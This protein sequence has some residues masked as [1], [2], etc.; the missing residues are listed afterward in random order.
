MEQDV[1]SVRDWLLTEWS[2]AISAVLESMADER[3]LVERGASPG[4]ANTNVSP[5][6]DASIWRQ[7]SALMDGAAIWISVSRSTRVDLGKKVLTSAGVDD[8]QE[9]DCK[10]VTLELISQSMS[11]LGKAVAAN[12][13][14]KAFADSGEE[15]ANAPAG[16]VWIP[17][18]FSFSGTRLEPVWFAAEDVFVSKLASVSSMTGDAGDP[19]ALAAEEP[20]PDSS[21]ANGSKTL[22]LLMDVAL[23]VSV[24]FGRTVLPV[25]EVLRLSTGSIVELD[26]A[27]NEPVDVIVNDCVIARGEVVV[28]EGNY[29]VRI[30]QI[31][32][33]HDRLR[34]GTAGT[35][36]PTGPP[37]NGG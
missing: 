24:S 13:N 16:L 37:A 15:I 17:L 26:R 25:H 23:P 29:G 2:E 22:E 31:A 4:S 10:S 21:P 6:E 11:A 18:T 30:Q 33:R 35:R 5:G 27:I 20:F 36:S 9:E 7:D 28:V 34:T 3:P 14:C 12:W 8:P 19:S 1:N 32:S